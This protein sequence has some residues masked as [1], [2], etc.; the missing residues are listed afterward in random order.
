MREVALSLTPE[1]ARVL[2][3]EVKAD[4]QALWAKLLTL[5]EGEA[6]VALGYTSWEAYYSA[7]FGQ[8]GRRGYQLL[9]AARVIVA[10]EPLQNFAMPANDHVAR[11]LVPLKDD[12]EAVRQ[13]WADAVERAG[14]AAPT[15]T[16]VREAVEEYQAPAAAAAVTHKPGVRH[17]RNQAK[18]VGNIARMAHNLTLSLPYA[19]FDTIKSMPVE[20]EWLEQLREARAMLTRLITALS[21]DA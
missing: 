19:D 2:T 4:A 11:E 7:E 1:A 9:E 8:S 3:D 10:L 6:H 18:Y 5:Y 14:D 16:L 12:P 15:A 13:V 17:T 21:K 20:A